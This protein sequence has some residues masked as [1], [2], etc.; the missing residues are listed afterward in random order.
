[1]PMFVDS[2]FDS[3]M[4]GRLGNSGENLYISRSGVLQR[5]NLLDINKDGFADIPFANSHDDDAKVPFF[6][7]PPE[8]GEPRRY[9]TEGAFAA[10]RLDINHDGWEDIVVANQYN[11]VNNRLYA[12]IYYGGEDGFSE[13]R[14]SKLWAPSCTSL[15][16]GDFDGDGRMEL[17]FYGWNR[18]FIHK[19]EENGFRVAGYRELP[20]SGTEVEFMAAGN[21][22]SERY[23]DLFVKYADDTVE[24]FH[25]GDGGIIDGR[26]EVIERGNRSGAPVIDTVSAGGGLPGLQVYKLFQ[27]ST[28]QVITIGGVRHL[29]WCA[30]GISRFY[31]YRNGFKLK[32]SLETPGARAVACGDL[33]GDGF[34]DLVFAASR[35]YEGRECSYILWGDRGGFSADRISFFPTTAARG[36]DI[37][38]DSILICQEKEENNYN[39]SCP[40]FTAD[41]QR[42]LIM[43]ASYPSHC[44]CAAFIMRDQSVTI[45]NHTNNSIL[46]RIPSYIYLGGPDGYSAERRVELIGHAPPDMKIVDLNDDG[47]PD[48]LIANCDENA[49][50]S[51]QPSYIY[52]QGEGGFSGGRLEE[53]PSFHTMSAVVADFNQDGYLDIATCGFGNSRVE[54]YYGGPDGFTQPPEVVEIVIDGQPCEQLRYM[55]VADFNKDGYLDIFVPVIQSGSS[56]LLYGG[57]E[58]FSLSNS[59][60]IPVENALSSRACDLDGDGYLDLIVGAY[61][62]CN[63]ANV[64][65]SFATIFWGGPDGFSNERKTMLPA[66]FASD[67]IVAD[68]NNDSIPDLFVTCYH[69]A[70]TRDLNSYIYWGEKGGIYREENRTPIFLHSCSGAIACDFNGDGYIDLAVA[71]H[72]TNGNHVGD[73]AVLWN[74]ELGFSTERQTLLPTLGTHGLSHY[75]YGNVYDRSDNEYYYSRLLPLDGGTVSAIEASAEVPPGCSVIID[76]RAGDTSEELHCCS[77]GP[78]QGLRG[79]LLQYR[80]NLY[81]K[82]SISTPRVTEVRVCFERGQ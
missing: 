75:D 52:Y 26:R 77:W 69:D 23:C 67:V 10:L 70:E 64:F 13:K 42:R 6:H 51:E 48:V 38:G 25:G 30:D 18:L 28:I 20:L 24:V 8:G 33:D 19:Q 55:T 82:Y 31:T 16:A 76:A 59:A 46:G 74:G 61:Q 36:A 5:I 40:L 45:V 56:I 11:G 58:G 49:L 72:K 43:K 65:S 80:L 34:E 15:A 54:I 57:K 12:Q 41:R 47:R 35:E 27:T 32:F 22:S 4:K 7:Y 2:G 60:I 9:F 81:S 63:P 62:G 3:F 44:A 1:M 14:C 66:Y 73:S 71:N 29:T 39:L 21:F 78:P 53:I 50:K 17:V 79:K 68:F 37:L